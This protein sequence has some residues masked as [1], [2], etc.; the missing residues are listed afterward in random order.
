MRPDARSEIAVIYIRQNHLIESQ[1]QPLMK[2]LIS[3]TV[4]PFY[5]FV[6]SLDPLGI[7][8]SSNP[9]D[10]L[11][12]TMTKR[13]YEAAS[14]VL[15]LLAIGKL[16]QAE[17]LSRTLMESSLS[18]LFITKGDVGERLIQYFENYIRGE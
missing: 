16:Q 11:L 9:C 8:D 5:L 2:T 6:E 10:G 1:I 18:L 3:E 17:V 4:A 7:A 15:S 12:I 14:G 13:M